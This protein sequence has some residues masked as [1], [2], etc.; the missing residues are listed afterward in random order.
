LSAA[1]FRDRASEVP[2]ELKQ[3]PPPGSYWDEELGFFVFDPPIRII[4]PPSPLAANGDISLIYDTGFMKYFLPA[5][6]DYHAYTKFSPP[7]CESGIWML[8]GAWLGFYNPER[9]YIDPVSV[10]VYRHDF[11]CEQTTGNPDGDR[12]TWELRRKELTPLDWWDLHPEGEEMDVAEFQLVLFDHPVPLAGEDFWIGWEHGRADPE[13]YLSSYTA[14]PTTLPEDDRMRFFE[15]HGPCP[16]IF[17]S[18]YGL[19]WLIRATGH[20]REVPFVESKI[21]IK[22][23]SCPNPINPGDIG[24]V[25]VAVVGTDVFDVRDVVPASAALNGVGPLRWDYEDVATPYEDELCGCHELG[26]DGFED[27]VYKFVTQDVYLTL[28]EPEDNEEVIVTMTWQTQD[29]IPMQGQDCFLVRLKNNEEPGEVGGGLDSYAGGGGIEAEEN[30]PQSDVAHVGSGSTF[31]L[32][33]NTPNPFK[34]R[35][36]LRFSLKDL[37]HAVLTVHDA[38]GRKV[39]SLVDGELVGGVHAVEWHARLPSGMYFCLLEAEG[40]TATQR[41]IVVR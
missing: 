14:G 18:Y 17:P 20:C 37:T 8:T 21:D 2:E 25:S 12:L 31:A 15:F 6:L 13:W 36:T 33:P 40:V 26:G 29:D 24:A 10:V 27:L 22:P 4:Q 34:D 16:V 3:N 23:M 1:G 19:S 7:D 9:G 28:D 39:A 30:G 38:T 5:Q 35:T 11:G 41:M 32:Y